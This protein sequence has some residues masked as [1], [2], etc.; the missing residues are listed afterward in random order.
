VENRRGRIPRMKKLKVN[1]VMS[2]RED[3]PIFRAILR[4]FRQFLP[5]EVEYHISQRPLNGMDIYHYHRPHQEETLLPNSVVTVHH[6]LR[7]G[8]FIQS[9]FLNR[10]RE[11][12]LVICLNTLQAAFLHRE[13][14]RHTTVVPHGF[15]ARVFT[16]PSRPKAVP[17]GRK[18]VLGFISKRYPTRFKGESYLL[19][20]LKRVDPGKFRFIFAGTGRTEDAW[21]ARAFGFEA[22]V[23]EHLPYRLFDQL[24]QKIDM[25]LIT[26]FF[27]GGPANVPEAGITATPILGTRMGMVHDF[28]RHGENGLFLSGSVS[29]D[30]ELFREISTNANGLTAAI[31]Q[32]AFDSI[33]RVISW[34]ENVCRNHAAYLAAL[35]DP[36]A[37][38]E[39]SGLS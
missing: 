10:Y 33:G 32:G 38:S 39:G 9:R 6:D 30:A 31:M 36:R 35:G 13:G 24:Y 34:E 19:E 25:L 7:D 29:Q 17:L 23:Y 14:I 37:E 20:L 11:A 27:E 1:H 3:S 18:I 28:L 2:S 4:Y 21:V 22:T 5:V 8:R 16:V 26:S 15:N 12:R